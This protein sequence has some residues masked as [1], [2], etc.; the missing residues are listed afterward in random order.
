MCCPG[1][2]RI[3]CNANGPAGRD[4]NRHR[5][6]RKHR[7]GGGP[8]RGAGWLHLARVATTADCESTKICIRG[9]LDPTKF[10]PIIVM[11]QCR[12]RDRQSE[13]RQGICVR[14]DRISARNPDKLICAARQRHDVTLTRTVSADGEGEACAISP[15]AARHRPPA[16]LLA[17]IR[18][19]VRH[20]GVSLP[21][22]AA[23]KLNCRVAS[24]AASGVP[25][26]RRWPK[27]S[28]G[29]EAVAWYG[30]RGAAQHAKN[31]ADKINA[32]VN[33]ALRQPR[34]R[35]VAEM[36]RRW[37]L[38]DRSRRHPTMQEE[39]DDGRGVDQVGQ[40]RMQ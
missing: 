36:I 3:G 6:C 15:I 30:I 9:R 37:S 34:C 40:H 2:S 24:P 28:P 25:D 8:T 17:A 1:S 31:I 23:G 19:D 16:G 20:L 5:C 29:F 35:I 39:V 14:V 4:E 21:L 12:T 10:E 33:E 11:A 38:A 26:V 22:V 27:R 7:L 13:H 18:R 32:D